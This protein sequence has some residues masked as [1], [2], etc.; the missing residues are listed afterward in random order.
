MRTDFVRF[1]PAHLL[2]I[3]AIPSF[4]AL[5]AWLVRQSLVRAR[6]VRLCLGFFLLVNELAW[7]A[8]RYWGEGIRF[9][10][11]LPL[12]LCD[13]GLWLTIVALLTLKPW[14][15]EVAYFV[16]LAGGG[17]AV[18]TP[19]L[20]APARS[21]PTSYFFL[22]H[23]ATIAGALFLAWGG[24]LRPRP[25]CVW[26]AWGVLNLY[27][28]GVGAVNAVFKTNFMYLCRKPAG[29]S[30]LDYMGPWPVY[31]LAGEVLALGL[32]TL[33]WLPFWGSNK[34]RAVQ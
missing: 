23:G 1:G 15:Y 34:Q 31:I 27:A 7:Q 24:V 25:G 8:Y 11:I 9:P 22:A 32:F 3:A 26:R 21:Y 4:A 19:D 29:A 16:A 5:L 20:Y 30:L 2:I 6:R 13:L 10:E 18:L 12:Q 33:L 14:S 28:A 17:M